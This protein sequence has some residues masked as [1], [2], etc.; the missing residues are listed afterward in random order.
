MMVTM[1]NPFNTISPHLLT[2]SLILFDMK[3]K[4]AGNYF[5]WS[6]FSTK[7]AKLKEKYFQLTLTT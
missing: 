5:R 3:Y 2:T 7:F 1:S 6:C 4:V